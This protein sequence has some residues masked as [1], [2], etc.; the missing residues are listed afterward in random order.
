MRVREHCGMRGKLHFWITTRDRGVMDTKVEL[1][2]RY[3][4]PEDWN[5]GWESA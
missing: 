1:W 2:P 4:P 5:L 3:D